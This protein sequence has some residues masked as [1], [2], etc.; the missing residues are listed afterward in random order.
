MPARGT[1]APRPKDSNQRN[2]RTG[3]LSADWEVAYR[4]NLGWVYR[5][6]YGRVGNRADAEDVTAE[7]FMRA[8]PRLRLAVPPAQLRAYLSTTA[9]SVLADHWRKAYDLGVAPY[10]ACE[11]AEPSIPADAGADEAVLRANRLLALLPNQYRRIL[12]LRFL[13]GRSIRDAAAELGISIGNAK[14]LQHRALRHAA[15][16][17]SHDLE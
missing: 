4:Q 14:V 3:D 2:N 9:R 11:L 7:V 1:L 17:G 12:E 8:L 10:D 16:I 5:F 13:Q 15:E 6:V